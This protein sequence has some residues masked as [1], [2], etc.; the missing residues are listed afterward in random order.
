M[1]FPTCSFSIFLL[2][3]INCGKWCQ[4]HLQRRDFF[5]LVIRN[6]AC[7]NHIT[8]CLYS[9]ESL[10][11]TMYFAAGKCALSIADAG[12]N[13]TTPLHTDHIKGRISSLTMDGHK[14]GSLT[15][16]YERAW[17]DL[18]ARPTSLASTPGGSWRRACR[19]G[20][21]SLYFKRAWLN[22]LP[23]RLRRACHLN[24]ARLI[25]KV[26]ARQ[27]RL[28]KEI[29]ALFYELMCDWYCTCW[30]HFKAFQNSLN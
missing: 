10:I 20:Q 16:R 2:F 13:E 17:D 30:I 6:P 4:P 21:A 26:G 3:R 5:Y 25:R 19:V 23:S 27:A 18:Q 24:K 7:F 1:P 14:P 11:L 15:A 28:K 8:F 12:A 22:E 9:N 29:S